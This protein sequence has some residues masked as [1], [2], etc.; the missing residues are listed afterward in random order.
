MKHS[1]S[2]GVRA[3]RPWV[4]VLV[5]F[6]PRIRDSQRIPVDLDALAGEPPAD[7]ESFLDAAIR[8]KYGSPGLVFAIVVTPGSNTYA[9]PVLDQLDA[10][11]VWPR[12]PTIT[13]E[14]VD[15]IA[16]LAP[17]VEL[18]ELRDG[19]LQTIERGQP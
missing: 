8:V 7:A 4:G 13:A 2:A 19:T 5:C 18:L 1:R 10:L 17:N 6:H 15:A 12:D 16:E 14:T 3:A 11:L 9:G